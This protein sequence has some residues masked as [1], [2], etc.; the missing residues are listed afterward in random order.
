MAFGDDA[1]DHLIDVAAD[2]RSG[3]KL[4]G[5]DGLVTDTRQARHRQRRQVVVSNAHAS[6]DRVPS[7]KRI[8]RPGQRGSPCARVVAS[9][10]I[11]GLS[12]T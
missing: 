9:S 2:G 4:S 3:T 8:E 12:D 10:A 1:I 5:I 6:L 7:P 11:S